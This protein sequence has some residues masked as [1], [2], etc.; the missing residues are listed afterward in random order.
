MKVFLDEK[1]EKLNTELFSMR[2]KITKTE[3]I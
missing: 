2:E 3:S 1:D